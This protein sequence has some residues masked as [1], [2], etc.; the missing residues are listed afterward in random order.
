MLKLNVTTVVASA[1]ANSWNNG[2][3]S[4]FRTVESSEWR[5][6]MNGDTMQCGSS[7]QQK[8][9]LIFCIR[10]SS[11]VLCIRWTNGF[12]AHHFHSLFSHSARLLYCILF[13]AFALSARHS[14]LLPIVYQ[15]TIVY[16]YPISIPWFCFIFHS[17]TAPHRNEGGIIEWKWKLGLWKQ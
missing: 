1:K 4:T 3:K 9:T 14:F 17:A 16:E 6:N 15:A 7:E 10:A 8:I 5:W 11:F 12:C 13:I 2:R